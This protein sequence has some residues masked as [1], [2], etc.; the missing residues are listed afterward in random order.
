MDEFLARL[1]NPILDRVIQLIPDDEPVYLVG[2]AIRDALLLRPVYDLDFVIP[3]NAMKLAR[4]I[5][6]KL[7]AAYFPLDKKRNMARIILMS[8]EPI[9]GIGGT[10]RRIDFSSFQGPDLISDLRGRDFTMNSM[11]VEVHQLQT[12]IDPLGGAA[13]LASKRLKA[14]SPQSILDDPIRILRAVR[15]SVELDL[16][17]QP[18]TR[19]LI[20]QAARLLP[21]ESAERL[22]DEL[23]RILSQ[24]RPSCALRILDILGALEFAMPEACMLK[25]IEQ[26]PPHIMDAWEHTLDFLGRL[27]IIL[28]VLAPEYNPDKVDNLTMG[29]LALYL[30]RFRN[31]LKEHLSNPLNPER[32]HRGLLFFAGLY[33][34]VGKLKARTMD[35]KGKIRFINHEQIGGK[36]VETRGKAMKLSN[37]EIERLVTIVNHH[38][39][40]SL[41]SHTEEI[42]SRK[43]I[44]RFFRDTGA[45]GVDIC[46]LSLA[47]I[48]AT[49]GPTIPQKRWTRHLEVVQMLLKAWWEDRSEGIFPRLLINGDDLMKELSI[50]PGPQVGFLLDAILEAQVGGDIHSRQEALNLAKQLSLEN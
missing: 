16:S 32:P 27:E 28:D 39:R 26:S 44:Y 20:R 33:H 13:D 18:E 3:G 1:S 45:A 48:L 30:G 36:L 19:Q 29:T 49:Y 22:R 5:A 42:P 4:Q 10:L 21:E 24:S 35:E 11:A 9:E 47:D 37:L 23:F 2:G 40:P 12:L 15:F 41:L 34:D 14:C 31:P 25:G 46:L 6:N 38:M 7:G 8:D 43:A 17:I 50:S